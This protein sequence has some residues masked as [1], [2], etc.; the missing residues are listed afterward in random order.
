MKKWYKSLLGDLETFQAYVSALEAANKKNKEL[1]KAGTLSQHDMDAQIKDNNAEFE[2]K[3]ASLCDGVQ[4]LREN[5]YKYIDK[6]YGF[7]GEQLT[8]DAQLFSGSIRFTRNEVADIAKRYI[9]NPSMLRVIR[10]YCERNQIEPVCDDLSAER[11]K[12][13]FDDSCNTA[14]QAMRS[15]HSALYAALTE[16]AIRQ[17]MDA[18]LESLE[19]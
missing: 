17:R 1:F 19:D 7:H 9:N 15:G 18:A 16:N 10:A 8:Q 6:R 4:R 13:A 5:A 3:R 12:I 2:Q 14:L 11:V